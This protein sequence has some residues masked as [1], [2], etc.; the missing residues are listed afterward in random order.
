MQIAGG[1]NDFGQRGAGRSQLHEHRLDQVF[2]ILLPARE[3]QR[4]TVQ[5]CGMAVV[6]PTKGIRAAGCQVREQLMIVTVVARAG[7]SW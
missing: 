1:R 3:R 5:R 2:R 6:E 7:H 4:M